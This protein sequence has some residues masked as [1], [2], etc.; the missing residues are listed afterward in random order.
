[1]DRVERTLI[2]HTFQRGGFR[3]RVGTFG[4]DFL[5]VGQRSVSSRN[6]H[7]TQLSYRTLDNFVMGTKAIAGEKYRIGSRFFTP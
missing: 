1:V 7:L 6:D 2:A 5:K 4:V 3:E